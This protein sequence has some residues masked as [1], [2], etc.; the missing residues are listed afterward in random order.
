MHVAGGI[1][2]ILRLLIPWIGRTRF[3]PDLDD[4]ARED[5]ALSHLA[6][7]DAEALRDALEH[8][9]RYHEYEEERRKD[10]FGRLSS[11]LGFAS[12]VVTIIFSFFLAAPADGRVELGRPAVVLFFYAAVQLVFAIVAA[13]Q[14]LSVR[15]YEEASVADGLL[16]P[17]EARQAQLVREVRQYS[18]M[19]R[20]H[21]EVVTNC[22][23]SLETAHRAA[24]NFFL[25]VLAMVSLLA[26]ARLGHG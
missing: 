20:N 15:E 19:C 9:R 5:Q 14:G 17:G 23:S 22:V 24:L 13:V 8:Y 7:L 2:W 10:A 11:V 26:F 6:G 12:I 16:A 1:R 18:L 21:E 25:A 4:R 3:S